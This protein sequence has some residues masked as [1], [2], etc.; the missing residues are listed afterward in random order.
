MCT[1]ERRHLVATGIITTAQ[2]EVR[3]KSYSVLMRR[4][5]GQLQVENLSTF[6]KAAVGIITA[7]CQAFNHRVDWLG[8]VTCL[9]GNRDNRGEAC[10]GNF[11]N[12]DIK[13]HLGEQIVRTL[14]LS[15]WLLSLDVGL[16]FTVVRPLL[17]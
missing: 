2:E 7:L 8:L 14:P 10:S 4:R 11:Y 3:I 6:Q 5:W 16:L 9:H 13:V 17:P 15:V 1:A 12:R